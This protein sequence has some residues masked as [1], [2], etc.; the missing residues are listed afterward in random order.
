MKLV[1]LHQSLSPLFEEEYFTRYWAL[2]KNE[3]VEIVCGGSCTF[4]L[5]RSRSGEQNRSVLDGKFLVK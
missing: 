2:F 1:S 3:V 4:F 5:V